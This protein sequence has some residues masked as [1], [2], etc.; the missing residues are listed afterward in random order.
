MRRIPITALVTV[1][2]V[3]VTACG[4]EPEAGQRANDGEPQGPADYAYVIPEGAGEALDRGEP[5][6]ILPA[7]LT[8]E[9][10][11]LIEIVN[12]DDRGHLLGPFYVG[13]GETLRQRFTSEGSFIGVCTVHPG[14]EL[15]LTVIEP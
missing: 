9:V 10:G 15:V 11:Q 1:L 6:E 8:V 2:I 13:A 4:G 14:G 12:E 3:A 5:L 7:E